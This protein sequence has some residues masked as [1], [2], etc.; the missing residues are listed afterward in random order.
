MDFVS[1]VTSNIFQIPYR[2]LKE[3]NHPICSLIA[4]SDCVISHGVPI[5]A[6]VGIAPS[7]LPPVVERTKKLRADQLQEQRRVEAIHRH[8]DEMEKVK[9]EG[10]PKFQMAQM[11]KRLV[12]LE[13]AKRLADEAAKNNRMLQPSPPPITQPTH[14]DGGDGIDFFDPETGK[15]MPAGKPKKPQ[16]SKV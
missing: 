3:G 11:Q 12:E 9:R 1:G 16:P 6:L 8:Q 2:L 15:M 4:E 5:V 10:D 13:A 7:E 14:A